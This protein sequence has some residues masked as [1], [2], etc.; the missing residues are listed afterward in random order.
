MNRANEGNGV[1]AK[2]FKIL[3]DDAVKMLHSMSANLE[4]AA[5][6][7]DWKSSVF[8]PISK[9]SN[10]KECSNYHTI[11]LISHASLGYSQ[12]PS[13]CASA[14]HE[15]RTSRCTSWVLKTQRSQRSNCQHSLG[16]GEGKGV[17]EKCL[18]M[19]HW[20]CSTFWSCG[21]QKTVEKF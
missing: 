13:S 17:P 21:S 4:N 3:K 1:P 2:V 12:N 6:A 15:L 10:T 18:H 19:L 7:T 14:V 8:I 9:K 20:L 11:L 16:H 5:V